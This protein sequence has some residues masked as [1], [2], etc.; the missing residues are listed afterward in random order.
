[1]KL[2][3]V[4]IH[5]CNRTWAFPFYGDPQHI[6]DWRA[7]G[8]EIHEVLNIVPL[9]VQRLGLVRPWCAVQDLFN[10]NFGVWK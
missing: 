10:F 6:P 7:D 8:L 3:T 4:T 2:M 1:M 9:W 5:G